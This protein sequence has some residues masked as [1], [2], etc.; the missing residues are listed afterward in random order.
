MMV[1]RVYRRLKLGFI[2]DVPT[3][4]EIP[5]STMTRTL[6][7]M[8]PRERQ[9]RDSSDDIQLTVFSERGAPKKR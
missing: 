3:V 7:F 4:V 2:Q 8:R 6:E 9:N 1:A 5:G